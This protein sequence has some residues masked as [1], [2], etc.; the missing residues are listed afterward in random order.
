MADRRALPLRRR[1]RGITRLI[2]ALNL[3][4]LLLLIAGMFWLNMRKV[5]MIDERILSLKTQGAIIAE[6]LAQTVDD[7][8]EAM[9][10]PEERAVPLMQRLVAK[11]NARTRLF[12]RKGELL[13]DSRIFMPNNEVVSNSLPAP[14]AWVSLAWIDA[15]YDGLARWA[16][17]QT[18]PPY[19]E[20]QGPDGTFYSEVALALK[21][22]RASAVRVNSTGDLVLSVAVPIQRFQLVMGVLHL[23][24]EGGD[25]GAIIRQER[26]AIMQ[27]SLVAV[28]VMIISSILMARHIAR[29]LR[30]L[31]DAADEARHREDGRTAIPDFSRRHD[32]IGE[33]SESLSDMTAALYDRI[34]SIEQFA[35]DVAHEIKNPLTSLKS[36]VE[37]M[38]RATPEQRDRLLGVIE[39]DV[40][41]VNRLVTDI[42]DASRLDAELARE[43][44][45][46]VD[47]VKLA[48]AVTQVCQKP[49]LPRIAV[50]AD[51]GVQRYGLVVNGLE[52]PL[53]QV[54]RNLID[55]AQSFSPM[56]EVVHVDLSREP[57]WA[58]IT[59]SDDGPGIPPEHLE[60]V[61]KRF[62]TSRPAEHFGQNSGLGLSISRQIVE[63]HR[64]QVTAA[65]APGETP[66][67]HGGAIFTV[68]LPLS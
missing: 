41:R 35:A 13:L 26:I 2:V 4:A 32:E 55:N 6:A 47:L 20:L 16:P 3:I 28:A 67:T 39:D 46:P 30:A 14:N 43:K 15:I 12:N 33:L 53:G 27:L 34:D 52:G 7:S 25:I 48:Q 17:G 45:V 60:N 19:I 24:N 66:D 38:R 9:D 44:A 31:A 64:G 51:P 42:S 1:R 29:P 59:V 37:T 11:T 63:V 18:Y 57:R 49:T 40:T 58:V 36:A 21:G 65:N 54:L 10:V 68:R 22:E 8:P 56:D 62:Y 50:S 23:T 5:G 61:F